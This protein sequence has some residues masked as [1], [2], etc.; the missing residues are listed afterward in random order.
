MQWPNAR[1]DARS[2]ET[3]TSRAPIAIAGIP[4]D[5]GTTNRSGARFGPAAIRQASRMLTD[6]AHPQSF[7]DPT[8]LPLADI[9]N[10]DL[11]LGETQTLTFNRWLSRAEMSAHLLSLPHAANS[12]DVYCVLQS[13]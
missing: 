13:G 5:L 10:F 2:P 12:G 9:G 1:L 7:V 8:A 3:M 11:A 4:L 6:G